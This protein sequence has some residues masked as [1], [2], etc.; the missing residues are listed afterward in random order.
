MARVRLSTRWAKVPRCATNPGIS[1]YVLVHAPW[2]QANEGRRFWSILAVAAI[3]LL[4]ILTPQASAAFLFDFA[5]ANTFQL[6]NTNADGSVIATTDQF[7]LTGGN[8][9][10]GDPGTTDFVATALSSGTVNFNWS[11][12]SLDSPGFDFAGYLLNG[13][14]FFLADTDGES[15]VNPCATCSFQVNAGQSF[16]FRVGTAD[17]QG[18]AGMLT[19]SAVTS[20]VPEPGT[21]STLFL[22]AGITILARFK[23]PGANRNRGSHQ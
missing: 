6:V 12:S 3:G 9:G 7:L 8:T 13:N 20:A 4:S 22:V 17:N 23:T 14:F 10:S 2:K 18:E 21:A 5:P 11:Y 19:V 15:G 1:L 16:G